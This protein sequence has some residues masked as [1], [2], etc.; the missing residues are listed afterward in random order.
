MA[1]A[2]QKEKSLL[3][4]LDRMSPVKLIILTLILFGLMVYLTYRTYL[5]HQSAFKIGFGIGAM[6]L[7][8][9]FLITFPATIKKTALAKATMN[10][11]LLALL[12]TTAMFFGSSYLI[13]STAVLLQLPFYL[14]FMYW[15]W[16]IVNFVGTP[17]YYN[18]EIRTFIDS[19]RRYLL[20]L[21]MWA[22][23]VGGVIMV[24]VA[25]VSTGVI[26]LPNTFPGVYTV[27]L[28]VYGLIFSVVTAFGILFLG[29]SQGKIS[30][31]RR[32]LLGLAQMCV[33][34]VGVSLIGTVLGANIE[35]SSFS[36]GTT[37]AHTFS[38]A[39]LG[40]GLIR[41]L[42]V[43]TIMVSFPIT[44]LYVWGLLKFFLLS[45]PNE[46]LT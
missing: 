26:P 7:L 11:I 18:D 13:R 1:R 36:P 42:C 17:S 12:I 29:Q 2:P 38:S 35:S 21:S 39:I 22:L 31:L 19:L 4:F 14:V 30:A 5:S 43:E 37:L 46:S 23:A 44:L 9:L 34:F 3:S 41:F 40:V 27:S 45:S 32:P 20:R 28:A 15:L 6:L 33:I 16:V 24:C 10:N 25:L 8:L